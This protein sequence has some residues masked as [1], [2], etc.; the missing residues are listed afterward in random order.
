MSTV[1]KHGMRLI[2]Y[3]AETCLQYY[4]LL[5]FASAIVQIVTGKGYVESVFLPIVIYVTFLCQKRRSGQFDFLVYSLLVWTVVTWTSNDYDKKSYLIFRSLMGQTAYV[6]AYFIGRN[7]FSRFHEYI[8]EKAFWPLIICSVIGIIFYFWPPGWYLAYAV[9]NSGGASKGDLFLEYFRLRSVFNHTYY[10]AY[11]CA[12]E[13]IYLLY[14]ILIK[15]NNVLRYKFALPLLF[16]TSMFTMMRAPIVCVLLSALIFVLYRF[17]K[18]YS[19]STILRISGLIIVFFIVGSLFYGKL[20]RAQQRFFS[21]KIEIATKATA[22]FVKARTNSPTTYEL[23]G[24]GV[25]RHASYVSKNTKNKV[26]ADCEYKKILTEYG[27]M[28]MI[29]IGLLLTV[30]LIKCI[31]HFQSLALETCI[32]VM[33]LIC[34]IGADPLS[35]GN[36]HCLIFWM[37]I[38]YVSSYNDKLKNYQ[39][40]CIEVLKL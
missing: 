34:M 24:E 40:R 18:G 14:Q 5:M 11:F 10:M 1:R 23:V 38:G 28:G 9:K 32:I 8:L 15:N 26:V 2:R 3:K 30:T 12:L 25:G 21:K 39:A 27:Y 19:I 16:V 37:V 13:S 36:K 35:T 31:Y 17:L 33:L 20:N 4:F 7:T 22:K 29:I 6:I